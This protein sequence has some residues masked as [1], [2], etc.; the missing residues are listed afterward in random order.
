MKNNKTVILITSLF[1]LMIFFS[2]I[3]RHDV[4]EDLHLR[5]AKQKQFDCVGQVSFGSNPTGYDGSCV[6]I[7]EKF[8]LSAAHVFMTGESRKD[9]V[10]MNGQKV[11]LNS[12]INTRVIDADKISLSF[13]GKTV[14][15]KKLTLHPNYLDG[16]TKGSC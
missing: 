7:N 1:A 2:G 15:V 11:V 6:L 13:N 5:L 9:T 3:I 10:M 14:K 12:P 8:G 16:Q 4:K